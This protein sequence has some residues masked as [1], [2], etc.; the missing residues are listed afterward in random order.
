MNTDHCSRRVIHVR[1]VEES[2]QKN[3]ASPTPENSKT[4]MSKQLNNSDSV[5]TSFGEESEIDTV[6]NYT[7]PVTTPAKLDKNP[8][9]DTESD[10]NDGFTAMNRGRKE[11]FQLL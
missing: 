2:V 3:L 5:T 7:T 1:T 4:K 8:N 10:D 6:A 9:S 11:S